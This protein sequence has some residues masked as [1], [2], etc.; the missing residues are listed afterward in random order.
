[1]TGAA[2]IDFADVAARVR[3]VRGFTP[4]PVGVGFGIR[5]AA[6]AKAIAALSDAVVI[7]S[8]LVQE[9]EKTPRDKVT[10]AVIRFLEPIRE[11]INELS[12]VKA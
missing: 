4:L 12:T 2:H 11:A 5:D 8:A 10:A 9:I 3:H 6:T 1:V 7:G